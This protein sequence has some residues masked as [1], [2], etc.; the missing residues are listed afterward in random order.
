MI[1]HK[2]NLQNPAINIRKII[3]N[4]LKANKIVLELKFAIIEELKII[5]ADDDIWICNEVILE[6]IGN[7]EK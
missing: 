1:K 4:L 2:Q 7:Y 5:Y 3:Y 6:F